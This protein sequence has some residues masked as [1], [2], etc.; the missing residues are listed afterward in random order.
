MYVFFP[1]SFMYYCNLPSYTDSFKHKTIDSMVT[2][3][4]WV[5]GKEVEYKEPKRRMPESVE[6]AKEMLDDM[7]KR[8]ELVH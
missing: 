8:G 6:E 5:D 2:R 3:Y 1:I 4:K 7:K